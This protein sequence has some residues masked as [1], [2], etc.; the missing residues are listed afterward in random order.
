MYLLIGVNVQYNLPDF[1]Q[2]TLNLLKTFK[3]PL[4]TPAFIAI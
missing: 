2:Q 4:E 1:F 3:Q